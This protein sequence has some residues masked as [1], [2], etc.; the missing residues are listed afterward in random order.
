MSDCERLVCLT[1]GAET[2]RVS[3]CLRCRETPLQCDACYAAHIR[4][5][6]SETLPPAPRTPLNAGGRKLGL[7]VLP[8][9]RREEA[10]R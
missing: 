2:P 6:H 4:E 10:E 1:C 7:P 9:P 8:K 5:Q 3:L